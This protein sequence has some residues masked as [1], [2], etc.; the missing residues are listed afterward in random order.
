MNL[1][2]LNNHYNLLSS[3][4]SLSFV[5]TNKLLIEYKNEL[6]QLLQNTKFKGFKRCTDVEFDDY[7][8][9]FTMELSDYNLLLYYFEVELEDTQ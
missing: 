9:L 4:T 2:L 7:G 3:L 8:L 1:K 5:V 6:N